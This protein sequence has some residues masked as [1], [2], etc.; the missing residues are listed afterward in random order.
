MYV[1]AHALADCVESA[2]VAATGCLLPPV[3]A[4]RPR[5]SP[6]IACAVVADALARGHSELCGGH[7]S[8]N[9]SSGGGDG[10]CGGGEVC[11]RHDTACVEGLVKAATWTP[12]HV[13]V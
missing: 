10:G 5:V 11:G 9:G 12:A 2:S 13:R 8:S 1:A 4:I 7:S 6:S 3:S